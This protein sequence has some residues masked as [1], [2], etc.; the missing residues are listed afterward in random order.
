M[1]TIGYGD[2]SP[3]TAGGRI[4]AVIIIISGIIFF[5]F[6]TASISSYLTRKGEEKE[7]EKLGEIERFELE[8]ILLEMKFE[9]ES[10]K[11]NN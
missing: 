9:I 11:E 2:I 1:T 7:E 8:K 10:L 3:V 4:V 6:F 5:G